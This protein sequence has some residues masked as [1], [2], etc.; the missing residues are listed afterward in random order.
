MRVTSC[1]Q[2]GQCDMARSRG[3]RTVSRDIVAQMR[4]VRNLLLDNGMGE[5]NLQTIVQRVGG[6]VLTREMGAC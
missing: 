1:L 6:R 3:R 4:R 5:S 2:R